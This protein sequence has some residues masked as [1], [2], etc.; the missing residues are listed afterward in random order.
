MPHKISVIWL[1]QGER[2]DTQSKI[3]HALASAI[4]DI[5]HGPTA[6]TS[7][8]AQI[9]RALAKFDFHTPM[10][11]EDAATEVIELLKGRTVHM[12]HP[13]YFGLFNPSVTFPGIVADQITAAINPQL[14]VC[15]LT[16]QFPEFGSTG[17][18]ALSA[19]PRLCFC[20]EP[21]GLAQDRTSGRHR[22]RKRM[23]GR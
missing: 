23:P 2:I 7:S 19:Q 10:A 21:S 8:S 16:R 14:A 1:S 18:R 3:A 20:R 22:A 12:M 11:V 17:A 9:R 13:G 4:G 5:A 15:A 6:P